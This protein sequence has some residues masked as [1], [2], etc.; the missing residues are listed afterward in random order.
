MTGTG[1]LTGLAGFLCVLLAIPLIIQR[2]APALTGR[3]DRQIHQT[4]KVPVPRLG[5]LALAAAFVLVVPIALLFA[6]S[7]GKSPR[8]G[9][10]TSFTA[11]LMFGLGFWDDLRPLGARKKLLGQIVIALLAFLCGLQVES[12]KNPISGVIYDLGLWGLPAT[13]LWLV[14]LTNLINLIDGIDGLA[15]GISLML[16][17]LL[18]YVGFQAN[19]FTYPYLVAFGM[20]GAL[21]A[22]LNFN[23]PPAKIYLGDGGAY[24][25]GYLIGALAIQNS[26]KGTVAAALI[27]PIFALALPIL[28][29]TL[30]ILRRG[31][32][33]LPIFR[34][35]RRH[36]HHRLIQSGFSRRRA[37]LTLYGISLVFLGLAFVAFWS[38]GKWTPLLFGCV[39]LVLIVIVP[40][41]GLLRN[42]LAIGS[43]LGTS[44][45]IRK[46]VQYTLLLRNWLEMEAERADSV[47]SLWS[48][49]VFM[50]RKIGFTAMTLRA[51]DAQRA[52]ESATSVS[53]ARQHFVQ[54]ELQIDGK[55]VHLE[56]RARR[57]DMSEKLFGVVTELVAEGWLN[58][59]LRWRECR[60]IPFAL[61][62]RNENTSAVKR[63]PVPS[64]P[65][66]L[67]V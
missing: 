42:W 6:A 53:D 60:E 26:N 25:L 7:E 8:L 66:S 50:A 64:V 63:E 49:L 52:W 10:T 23:F 47:E 58:A 34:P 28:D 13:V 24:F 33:G 9:L 37:V 62:V 48:D 29:V 57:S 16:M 3:R 22:F 2:I 39:F 12:F 19:Q 55:S 43:A 56:F 15:G 36:I 45:E 61:P 46:Q 41:L 5:G 14:T 44:L 67:P 20:A 32:H 59:S 38:R 18:V 40:S 27:A 31:L 4:H 30:S 51:G 17:C 65:H 1:L 35:D 21:I 11:L 54:H